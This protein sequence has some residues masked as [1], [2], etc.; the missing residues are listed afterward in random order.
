MSLSS[1]DRLGRYEVL[2]PLGVGGMGEVF[3]ARDTELDR[4]VAIKVLPH[5]FAADPSRIER[6]QRE[7]RAL[8][9][10]SH[11]NLLEVYDVG[12]SN[13]VHY[14]VTELLEGQSLRERVPTGGLPWQK[15]A[16]MGAPMAEGLAAA[17]S[18]GIIHRDLKPENIF[19]TTDGRVKILDFGLAK[20]VESVDPD[21]E[22]GT[23]TPAGTAMGTILGTMGY[24]SPEQVKGQPADHRSDIFALGCVL[25]EMVS[26]RRAFAS[27]TTA[28][29]IAAVLKEEP[30]QLS[31]TGA[32]LPVDLE[33]SI[34]RCLEKEPAARYQS[35]ADLGFALRSIGSSPTR[36]AMATPSGDVPGQQGRKGWWIGLAAAAAV[37]AIALLAWWQLG[38]NDRPAERAPREARVAEPSRIVQVTEH[39]VVVEDVENRTGDPSLDAVAGETTD[40][41]RGALGQSGF[42][43]TPTS[44]LDAATV[45]A[46]APEV[47]GL[48]IEGSI[49]NRGSGAEATVRAVELESRRTMWTSDP[50]PFRRATASSDLAP[51]ISRSIAAVHLWVS[52]VFPL[53]H[54]SHVPEFEIYQLFARAGAIDF[55]EYY[56]QFNEYLGPA[57]EGDPAFVP[58]VYLGRYR[59]SI[60]RAAE[61]RHRATGDRER[62]AAQPEDDRP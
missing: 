52:N 55:Y 41:I 13:G 16:E 57:L 17:H 12:S 53:E 25:Y 35:A 14:V 46:K 3:R 33:R 1:G 20:V 58:A 15:V 31:S 54:L 40:L 5:D 29:I 24:M 11:P 42:T 56:A 22:T 28:E 21:A 48:V 44:E 18:K 26:G 30:P 49:A 61:R 38:S 19:V 6:F 23:M 45:R 62:P 27:D 47:A 9:A 51:L 34:H 60:R 10:L 39:L 50:A 37:A 4:R 2:E 59:E 7:A 36:P 43:I 8:A 32:A